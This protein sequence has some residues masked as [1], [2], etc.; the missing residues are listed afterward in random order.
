MVTATTSFADVED[1]GLRA[2]VRM[3]HTVCRGNADGVDLFSFRHVASHSDVPD[4]QYLFSGISMQ[5]Y[6]W[7]LI[8]P[9]RSNPAGFLLVWF[10]SGYMHYVSRRSNMSRISTVSASVRGRIFSS[11]NRD[12]H[13]RRNSLTKFPVCPQREF[14]VFVHPSWLA[15]E[16][17]HKVTPSTDRGGHS[18]LASGSS[19]FQSW[20]VGV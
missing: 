18:C 1:D 10:N 20:A 16:T 7:R 2:S 8:S 14:V 5:Q 11:G 9:L 4:N 17:G 15:T 12:E 13:F 6:S 3:F 19:T